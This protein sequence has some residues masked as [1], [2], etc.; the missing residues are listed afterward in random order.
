MVRLL[1]I[2]QEDVS[3]TALL[4][5]HHMQLSREEWEYVSTIALV[6]HIHHRYQY[7]AWHLVPQ[8]QQYT[9]HILLQMHVLNSAYTLTS[10]TSILNNVPLH[11]WLDIMVMLQQKLV[12]FVKFNVSLVLVFLSVL[13]ALLAFT[14]IKSVVLYHVPPILPCI[15]HIRNQVSASWHALFH[16]MENLQL[17]FA[18]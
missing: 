8:V 10:L 13:L 12:K 1:M 14:Y 16:F 7:H 15:L 17:N 2:P 5:Q 18:N 4:P 11:V 3:T 6:V 9:T